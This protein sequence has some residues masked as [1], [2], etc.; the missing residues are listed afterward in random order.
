MSTET[1]RAVSAG[2]RCDAEAP[3]DMRHQAAAQPPAPVDAMATTRRLVGMAFD[4]SR[5]GAAVHEG[6]L[7]E[8][9]AAMVA[10]LEQLRDVL[11]SREFTANLDRLILAAG[12]GAG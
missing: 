1:E 6:T 10:F 8:R 5:R 12:D 11:R 2:T 4:L 3:E 7:V 9:N